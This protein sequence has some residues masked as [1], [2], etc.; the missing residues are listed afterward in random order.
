V[1][2]A[3]VMEMTNTIQG[4]DAERLADCIKFAAAQGLEITKHTQAGLNQNSGNVW[5][6]D[7]DWPGCIYQDIGFSGACVSWH[8]GECGNEI[9][10]KS[11]KEADKLNEQFNE[12][13]HCSEC[14]GE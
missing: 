2:K 13:E 7:E 5:L 4:A 12:N 6:W 14:E 10:C 9:D 11:M 8:C 3:D 1:G